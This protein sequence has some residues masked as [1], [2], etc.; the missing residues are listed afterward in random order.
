VGLPVAGCGFDV[1][2]IAA[3][4]PAYLRA[5]HLAYGVV[6][7]VGER[8]A[9]LVSDLI[10]GARRGD[11]SIEL[12]FGAYQR[13]ELVSACLAVESSGGAALV[14]VP[15]DLR[16]PTEC[17]GA[18]AALRALQEA[19]WARSI[20]LLEA[21]PVPGSEMLERVLQNAGFRCLTNLRYLRRG[22]SRIAPFSLV[23]RDLEWVSYVPDVEPLFQEAIERSYVQSLDCPE[24]TGLR[25]TAAALAGHRA[26]GIFD[27]TCWWV[28]KR[29][30]EPVGVI[31]LNRMR[32]ARGLE[33]VYMGVAQL[34]RGTGVAD[35]L[36]RR[37]VEAAARHGDNI[38]A[39]AVDERNTPARRMYAR[40]GF[41]ETGVRAAWIATPPGI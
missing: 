21:L 19:A 10:A 20:A 29:H 33:V 3:D 25:P 2:L 15:T 22:D 11:V 31:L 6:L 9:R 38:L 18:A 27:P 23:V 16:S 17:E 1:R 32:S 30:G 26:T 4:S 7:S 24:L 12:L 34:A 13:S 8:P 28:V 14:F 40:W 37:A 35:A 39:L 41:V 36:L 5:L